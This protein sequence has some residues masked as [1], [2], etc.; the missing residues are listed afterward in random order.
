V[1]SKDLKDLVNAIIKMIDDKKKSERGNLQDG[2]WTGTVDTVNSTN[3]TASILMPN[4]TTPT[5]HK[6][7]KTSQT[8]VSGDE[9]YLFSPYGTLGSAWIAVA[10]KKYVNN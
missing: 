2:W 7:N 4:E 5:S 8:L 1:N 3:N 6:Q 9:V 10:K